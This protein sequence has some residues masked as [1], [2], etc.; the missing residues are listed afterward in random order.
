[1]CSCAKNIYNS[2]RKLFIC[3]LKYKTQKLK[4]KQ[5][6]QKRKSEK[7]QTNVT[8]EE[9][10]K[11]IIRTSLTATRIRPFSTTVLQDNTSTRYEL[12]MTG[13]SK[14][15]TIYSSRRHKDCKWKNLISQEIKKESSVKPT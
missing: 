14:D 12:K 3:A 7:K 4:L 6:S 11:L 15:N 9:K 2:N 8:T 13:A 5:E 10:G 1:M